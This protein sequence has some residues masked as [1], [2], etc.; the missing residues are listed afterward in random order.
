[1]AM[2]KYVRE[3]WNK[4]TDSMPD[5]MKARKIQWR[6]EPA[7][8]RLEHPTRIDRARSL[9]YKAKQGIFVVRQRVQRGGHRKP[10]PSAGRRSKKY[11]TRK[12]LVLNYQTISEQRALQNYPNCEVLNSY[13][14]AKDGNHIWYEVIMVDVSHP[15]IKA[16]SNLSWITKDIHRGRPFRG[17]TSSAKRS[18]GLLNKGKGAEKMRPSKTANRKRRF[19]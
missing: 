1:M 4:P 5:L 7:T 9:G 19:Y 2:Y 14:V 13:E 16:D 18:R 12:S 17:L 8:V 10:L 15:A 11:T 6:S 3:L